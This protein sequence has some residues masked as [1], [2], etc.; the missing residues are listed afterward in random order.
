MPRTSRL[1]ASL[2]LAA[3]AWN[4]P[5]H[6]QQWV[7]QA[8]AQSPG[9]QWFLPLT[10]DEFNSE[11]V[12]FGGFAG[13]WFDDTWLYANGTWRQAQPTTV[14]PARCCHSL[15]F[16]LVRGRVVMFGGADASN[17]DINDTWEW[18]GANWTQMQPTNAPSPRRQ[19]RMAF[20]PTRGTVLLFGGGTGSSGTTVFDDTWAWDGTNWTQ[21][22][23]RTTPP[24]R[25][26]HAL[27]TDWIRAEMVMFGGA[28]RAGTGLLDDTWLWDGN[29]WRLATT[30]F[31]PSP[32]WRVRGAYSSTRSRTVFVGDT[33]TETWEWDGSRWWLSDA[34]LPGARSANGMAG[35]LVNPT[36][37]LYGGSGTNTTLEYLADRAGIVYSGVGCGANPPTITANTLAVP[38]T[39]LDGAVMGCPSTLALIALNLAPPAAG[40]FDLASFGAPGCTAEVEPNGALVLFAPVMAGGIA[41]WSLAIPNTPS[42]VGLEVYAQGFPLAPGANPTGILAT[43]V[44]VASVF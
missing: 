26:S 12:L 19:P 3:F 29:D 4:T 32:R 36:T 1:I 7:Q 37:V 27:V 24:A 33:S 43:G 18:D 39:S 11:A 41:A 21:L 30:T 2:A 38:G 22:S 20:D 10:Y 13:A 14:P 31:G 17:A 42:V 6:A 16:D 23:P 5:V 15:A 8:T 9:A 34:G 35:S 44:C 40:P 25:W 28:Q